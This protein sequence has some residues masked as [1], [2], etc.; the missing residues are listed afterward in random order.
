MDKYTEKQINDEWNNVR[1]NRNAYLAQT[2]WCVL[3][4][5]PLSADLINAIKTYRQNLRDITST[6][7]NPYEVVF[8]QNPLEQP[9][10]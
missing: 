3:P 8:P 4:D 9:V 2:D 1:S 10:E 5:S 6:Y 7:T